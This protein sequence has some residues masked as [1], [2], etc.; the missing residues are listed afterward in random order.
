MIIQLK[1][2]RFP[3]FSSRRWR[4]A[5]LTITGGRLS[6][7]PPARKPTSVIDAQGY[8]LFPAFTDLRTHVFA[9]PHI[10]IENAKNLAAAALTG[11]YSTVLA[12]P[13]APDPVIDAET[14]AAVASL[15]GKRLRVLPTAAVCDREGHSSDHEA[16]LDAGAFTLADDGYA[17]D[18]VLSHAMQVCA[19]RGLPIIC[20]AVRDPRGG[21]DSPLAEAIATSRLLVLA[22]DS[23]CRLHITGVSAADAVAA[24]RIAKR[25]GVPVTADSCPPYFTMTKSDL[26]FYG[27]QVKLSHPLR[28]RRDIAAI[29]EALA[30]QTIDAVSTD[31]TPVERAEKCLPI[32]RA[33]AGM[34]ALQT[35]FSVTLGGLVLPGQI[36]LFRLIELLSLAPSKI[37]GLGSPL[38][39]GSSC[40]I[41]ICDINR[42]YTYNP[43]MAGENSGVRNTPYLGQVLIGKVE[44]LV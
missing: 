24:I 40:S 15:S 30:D 33:T 35:A 14:V 6:F 13:F 9:P 32:D 27:S 37:L 5:D 20:H 19:A 26:L 42:R 29:I 10:R 17:D 18:A 31:H 25:E 8:L 21:E 3:D 4:P 36:D 12:A 44:R 7:A 2:G 22:A 39:E 1:N 23:G 28:S 43:L 16:L 11:G 34:L 38:T 41:A